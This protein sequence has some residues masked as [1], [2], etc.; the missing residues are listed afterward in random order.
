MCELTPIN[1]SLCSKKPSS[2]HTIY[3]WFSLI[4]LVGRTLAVSLYSAEINDES[5]KIVE[6][7][8]VAP[9]ESWCVELKRFYDEVTYD[10]VALTGM[11]FFYLTKRLVLSV[12]KSQ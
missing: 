6:V 2:V 1:V 3:F 8:R 5:K 7:I 11:K 10:I 12:I 9:K 4:F